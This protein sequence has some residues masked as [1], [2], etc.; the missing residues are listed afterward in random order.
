MSSK[1]SASSN[2]KGWADVVIRFIDALYDLAQTGNIFGLIAFAF[3]CWV[4]YI[5][6]KMPSEFLEGIFGGVGIFLGSEKFYL[7][8]LS[9][10]L[11]ISVITNVIQARVYKTHIHDLTEQRKYLVHGNQSGELRHLETHRSS[12]FDIKSNAVTR[13]QGGENASG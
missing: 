6:Y 10:V 9:M 1:G 12:R 11:C 7:F 2:T 3:V 5:T 13:K 4:F 8:P